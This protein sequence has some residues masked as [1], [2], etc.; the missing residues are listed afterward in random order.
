MF[1]F[2]KK[3]KVFEIAGAK[4][5][6]QIG[7]NPL[8]LIGSLFYKARKN[9]VLKNAKTG[10]FDAK[11][12][13]NLINRQIGIAEKTG[14]NHGFDIGG[15][16]ESSDAL[17]KLVEFVADKTDA[18]ILPGG[19]NADI[20]APAVKHFGEIGLTEQIIYNSIE[21]HA[22]KNEIEAIKESKITSAICLA[23]HSRYIWP[24]DKLKLIIGDDKN[25][26]LLDK[27]KRAGVDKILLDTATLDVPSISINARTIHMIKKELGYPAGS[28]THNA[29]Q[30]WDKLKEFQK[31][32]KSIKQIKNVQ[33]HTIPQAL[34][35][36]FFLYG[37]IKH[38]EY[39]FPMMA[40][41]E[42]VLT[43]N[44]MRFNKISVNRDGPLFK[45]F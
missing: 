40:M 4:I 16:A 35:S 21:P 9:N 10:E 3:Q 15:G 25:E 20:R 37:P 12:A 24:K 30:T 18:P 39:I 44:A 22:T 43:Y 33:V 41:N 42:A 1:I 32:D 31:L 6:G 8:F 45:I 17:I 5:G 28:G 27:A 26:G 7:E 14:L 29:L 2:E 36:D 38:C 23:F 34:G 13:K 19:P 11:L